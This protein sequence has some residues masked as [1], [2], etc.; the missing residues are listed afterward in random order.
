[1]AREACRWCDGTCDTCVEL[2]WT[3]G[4]PDPA[5][6]AEDERDAQSQWDDEEIEPLGF[7]HPKTRE[8]RNRR[9]G[10]DGG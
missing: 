10:G 1:M 4:E 9:S 6:V 2:C 5:D 8:K 7:Y 3:D